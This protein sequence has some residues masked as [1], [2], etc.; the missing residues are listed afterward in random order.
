MIC[1]KSRNGFGVLL[2][3][4][5]LLIFACNSKEEASDRDKNTRITL[6]FIQLEL[7]VDSTHFRGLNLISSN[8]VWISGT[9]GTYLHFDGENW[10]K[11]RIDSAKG[12]DLRDIHVLNDSSAIAI[13]AGSPGKLFKTQNR[14][15]FWQQVYSNYDSL[16]FFDGMDFH[17]N[18]GVAF[19]DPMNGKVKLIYSNN[20]GDS[21]YD[22][23][24][25]NIPNALNVEA[26]FAASGT[27]IRL[28]DSLIYI[29]L[30]GEKARFMR[31]I[32]RGNSWEISETPLLHGTG[33]KGIYSIAFKDKLNGVAVG[34][35]WENPECDSSKAY[36][37][38]GGSTWQLSKGVQGYRSCVTH[39]KGNIYMSTGTTGTDISY[40]NGKSW[41]F[42]DS[43]GLNA[44][45]FDSV[46]NI[47]YGVGNYGKIYQINLK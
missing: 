7:D 32:N 1:L 4:F 16:I 43:R 40:D 47:G 15:V 46:S 29:G 8:N 26:G 39:I 5:A 2:F 41:Q 36:T 27:G 12:L 25:S 17:E 18:Y 10:T 30:G 42:I 13:S 20:Y 34:G 14:G 6:E 44:I 9:D 22:F 37:N 35:N 19:G 21:W 33:S 3:G 28:F 38:D 45:Q 24:T 11:G 31:S 23:D